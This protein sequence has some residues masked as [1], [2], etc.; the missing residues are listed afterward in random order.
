[1]TNLLFYPSHFCFTLV[2]F[3]VFSCRDDGCFRCILM[4]SR[5][6][7]IIQYKESRSP[8]AILCI[9]IIKVQNNGFLSLPICALRTQQCIL[10]R[11]A[12][13]RKSINHSTSFRF[14]L[15]SMPYC[16][17][18]CKHSSFSMQK[19]RFIGLMP[20]RKRQWAVTTSSLEVI[21]TWS[22]TMCRFT[23]CL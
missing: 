11:S 15:G 5:H 23:E 12:N 6:R 13:S 10:L 4:M 19:E 21:S 20:G 14:A 18:Y 16:S 1:M 9:V 8:S 7:N 2:T 22:F 17:S 3:C